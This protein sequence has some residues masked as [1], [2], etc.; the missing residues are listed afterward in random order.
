ML[1]FRGVEIKAPPTIPKVLQRPQAMT[2]SPDLPA[3]NRWRS[4]NW[5]LGLTYPPQG[6]SKNIPPGE[7]ENSS[8]QVGAGW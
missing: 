6:T 4:G 3:E 8:T 7:K 2:N 5:E 1:I